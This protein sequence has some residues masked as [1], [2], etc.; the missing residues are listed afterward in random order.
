[1]SDPKHPNADDL[2]LIVNR[3]LIIEEVAWDAMDEVNAAAFQEAYKDLVNLGRL[4]L[5]NGEPVQGRSLPL[6]VR[7][8]ALRTR[9]LL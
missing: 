1:M 7:T 3:M 5:G 6:R 9:L 8:P 2:P 4:V